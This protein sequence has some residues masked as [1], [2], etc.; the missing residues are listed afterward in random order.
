MLSCSMTNSEGKMRSDIAAYLFVLQ[1]RINKQDLS[2]KPKD[3]WEEAW[4][5]M[6]SQTLQSICPTPAERN[7][8]KSIFAQHCSRT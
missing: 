2:G 1:S 6:P 8:A 5:K 7:M 4:I 3:Y